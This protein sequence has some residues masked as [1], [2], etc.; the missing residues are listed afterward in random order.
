MAKTTMLLLVA[1]LAASLPPSFG[2]VV[3]EEVSAE[4]GCA[5]ACGA[6]PPI[7]AI[8]GA[9]ETDPALALCWAGGK[10]GVRHG[11]RADGG[12]MWVGI[13]P[14]GLVGLR[15]PAWQPGS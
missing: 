11:F 10:I 3:W 6:L 8:D 5:A 14:F 1:L 12:G 2:T 15:G 13:Q 7:P 9:T 4:S